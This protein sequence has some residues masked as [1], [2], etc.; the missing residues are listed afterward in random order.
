MIEMTVRTNAIIFLLTNIF[1]LQVEKSVLPTKPDF[2]KPIARAA[3][4]N[5]MRKSIASL[6]QTQYTGLLE[7]FALLMD[8]FL[9][10]EVFAQD[11]LQVISSCGF[12]VVSS[13][14]AI[15]NIRA[16]LPI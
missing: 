16:R 6:M 11:E 8:F 7:P 4:K 15:D 3:M 2:G 1:D 9:D 12:S 14:D 5:I 13:F 10:A